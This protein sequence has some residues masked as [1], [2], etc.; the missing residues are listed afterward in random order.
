M[1]THSCTAAFKT[2]GRMI[3]YK[4]KAS[5]DYLARPCLKENKTTETR[6]SNYEHCPPK[7]PLVQWSANG[8]SWQE[9]VIQPPDD[10]FPHR[11][12]FWLFKRTKTRRYKLMSQRSR[13]FTQQWLGE[14][15]LTRQSKKQG[16]ESRK[17]LSCA[18]ALSSPSQQGI[19]YIQATHQGLHNPTW[20]PS[21][22][23][24]RARLR[25]C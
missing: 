16:Q 14:L 17:W 19:Y 4:S 13:T 18:L 1:V 10:F 25:C 7:V 22:V 15:F 24:P 3:S 9:A 12:T 23:S 5:Q 21:G 20:N 8:P 11:T 2:K 6:C